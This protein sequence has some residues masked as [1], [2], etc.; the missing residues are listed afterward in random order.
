MNNIT[1]KSIEKLTKKE[2]VAEIEL[3]KSQEYLC[4]YSQLGED[5]LIDFLMMYFTTIDRNNVR[6]VDIGMNHPIEYNNTYFFHKKNGH[7]IVIEPNKTLCE[8]A[9]IVR[10]KDIIVNAGVKFDEKDKATY[11]NFDTHGLNTFDGNRIENLKSNGHRLVEAI[12]LP[13]IDINEIIEDE[14]PNTPI[15]LMSIDAEGVDFQ[16]L[17]LINF[18]KHRPKILC[19]EANKSKYEFG[20]RDEVINFMENLNYILMGDTTINY[21]FMDKAELIIGRYS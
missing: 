5:K 3:L 8:I 9:S 21:I 7:G 15:D 13:L 4:S 6:Y 17:K 16:I 10:P 2:L 12:E 19:I 11:Y 1:K 14:M 18:K 20:I